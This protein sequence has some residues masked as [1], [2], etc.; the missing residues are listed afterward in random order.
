M[1]FKS[2]F[3]CSYNFCYI[4]ISTSTTGRQCIILW[5]NNIKCKQICNLQVCVC[6]WTYSHW[7]HCNQVIF[8]VWHIKPLHKYT[9]VTKEY[10]THRMKLQVKG[11]STRLSIVRI[12]TPFEMGPL[13]QP[14]L[15][16]ACLRLAHVMGYLSPVPCLSL[17]WTMSCLYSGNNTS[18]G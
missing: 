9:S 14:L 5:L 18:F 8:D 6:L 2:Y 10:L 13:I 17:P 1:F 15:F 12:R 4:F 16:C 7:Q 3:A 11:A